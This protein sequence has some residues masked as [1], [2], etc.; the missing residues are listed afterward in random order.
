MNEHVEEN[1]LIKQR[2]AKLESITSGGIYA[3]GGRFDFSTDIKGL[4]DNFSEGKT[5]SV[6]GRIM[7]CREHGKSLFYDLKD[8]SGKIQA[9]I[10]ADII[11]PPKFEFLKNLD[12]GDFVGVKGDTFKTRTGEPTIVVKELTI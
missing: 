8:S 3:Y 7:A 12:I 4:K 1:E 11:G 6:A 5:V 10:K 2:K 9:Y